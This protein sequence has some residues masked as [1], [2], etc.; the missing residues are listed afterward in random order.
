MKKIIVITTVALALVA[1]VLTGCAGK[2]PSAVTALVTT[3]VDS[4]ESDVPLIGVN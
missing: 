4:F 3:S 2:E 1:T